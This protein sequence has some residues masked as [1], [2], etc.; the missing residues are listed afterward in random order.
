[1]GS[2]LLLIGLLGL[3]TGVGPYDLPSRSRQ[4]D[5]VI[6]ESK[7]LGLPMTAA[8]LVGPVPSPE[9]NAAPG[10]LEAIELLD[11]TNNDFFM[12][13]LE[14]DAAL[15]SQQAAWLLNN[16]GHLDTISALLRERPSW[17]VERDY[18]LGAYILLPEFANL[19]N[20]AKTLGI[21]GVRSARE[22]DTD[23]A[24]NDFVA[25]RRLAEKLA[26]E[27]TLIGMLVSIAIDAISLRSIESYTDSWRGDAARLRALEGAVAST[28]F[29]RD[30]R[31]ALR[32]EFYL[33]LVTC[34]NLKLYGGLSA[35]TDTTMGLES[36]RAPDP[37]K[38]QRTGLPHGM[39]ERASMTSFAEAWNEVFASFA[40]HGVRETKWG[41]LLNARYVAMESR[42]KASEILPQVLFPVFTQA[43]QALT[44]DDV[45][46]DLAL[47][48]V[49]AFRYRAESGK[50]PTDLAQIESAFPDPFNP[51]KTIQAKFS[52]TEV[53]VWSVGRDRKDDGGL[54][55]IETGD[56]EDTAF[57]WPPS[58]RRPPK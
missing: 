36:R 23:L 58:L 25:S 4:L 53:R 40:S 28:K 39:F 49:R 52:E 9:D 56:G 17:H 37:S 2:C 11:D 57:V 6:A 55:R 15:Q 8:E 19:K 48:F 1:M 5:D 27:P 31:T 7:R 21:R 45:N 30:P 38:I 18:D 24:I 10:V 44:N 34:R 22:K 12:T 13:T 35:L 14:S 43:E 26:T 46:Q 41:D 20:L 33:E 54:Q 50:W 42:F 32:G 47:A 29:V 3:V 51:G 16:R